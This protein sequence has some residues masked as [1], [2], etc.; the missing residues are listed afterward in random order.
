MLAQTPT[1][2][3][4]RNKEIK[5]ILNRHLKTFKNSYLS[6]KTRIIK[7]KNKKLKYY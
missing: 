1:T 3:S 4:I 7:N 2:S 5:Q 6:G